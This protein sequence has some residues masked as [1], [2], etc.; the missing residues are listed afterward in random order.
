MRLTKP[1]EV[2]GVLLGTGLPKICVPLTAENAGGLAE[3]AR[4]AVRAGA[5]L[6]EWRFDCFEERS[7]A[8]LKAGLEV[9]DEALRSGSDKRLPLLFTIRTRPEGGSADLSLEEYIRLNL[10]AA[11]DER[12]DLV[13]VEV[14]G[15]DE[16][17]KELIRS[18]QEH[19]VKVIG[20]RHYFEETPQLQ[21]LFT[22]LFGLDASGADVLKLAVMPQFLED[23]QMLIQAVDKLTKHSVH[24]VI[25]MSMGEMG[26]ITRIWGEAFGSCVTFGTAGP[27]SAPGQMPAE[28]LRE[29]LLEV[30]RM[31]QEKEKSAVE[32]EQAYERHEGEENG[33]IPGGA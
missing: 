15:E 17:K 8:G 25:A 11:S 32:R 29:E 9:L 22:A 21:E 5:D 28:K 12:V 30:H 18:L 3:Q 7:A 4:E 2:R 10:L 20:S 6:T 16:K 26:R 19:G 33:Q 13:D 1:V 23:V 31:L 14:F 24:P 27:A